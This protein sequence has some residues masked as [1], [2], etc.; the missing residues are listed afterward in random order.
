METVRR[1]M[2]RAQRVEELLW[3]EKRIPSGAFRCGEKRNRGQKFPTSNTFIT[4]PKKAGKSRSRVPECSEGNLRSKSINYKGTVQRGWK[5]KG[6]RD[7]QLPVK[8]GAIRE[9][10]RLGRGFRPH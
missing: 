10:G 3:K 8:T 6:C 9:G 7:E 4:E 1:V 5:K 2:I